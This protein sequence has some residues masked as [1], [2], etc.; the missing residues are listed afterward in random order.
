MSNSGFAPVNYPDLGT[1]NVAGV[2]AAQARGYAAG[3]AEGLRRAAAVQLSAERA[4]ESEHRRRLA[5]E[6]A[7]SRQ[8]A[9]AL[10]RAAE[11]ILAAALPLIEE[12]D[13]ALV[14]AAIDLAEAVLQREVAGGHVTAADTLR[15]VLAA[16]PKEELVAVRLPPTAAAEAVT[17]AQTGL[18][19]V[20]MVA[21][22]SLAPGD[23]VAV[24][25]DGWLD[26]RIAA[27][28]S[29]AKAVLKPERS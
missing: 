3:Y 18:T 21:D 4:R 19:A 22:E 20:E 29:R 11:Q 15:R 6:K 8:A 25:R 14:E 13:E 27:S 16:V 1:H 9:T 7:V 23:A 26:A 24:L 17:G 2:S 5:E 28:L 12:V 10:S